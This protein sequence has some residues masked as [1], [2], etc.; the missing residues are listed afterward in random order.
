VEGNS[1]YLWFSTTI[2]GIGASFS[3]FLFDLVHSF[4]LCAST[5]H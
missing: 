1:V 5:S 4:S 2:Q 3:S